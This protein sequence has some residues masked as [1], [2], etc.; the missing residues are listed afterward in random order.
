MEKLYV[1]V[2][3]KFIGLAPGEGKGR[4][5]RSSENMVYVNEGKEKS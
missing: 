2:Q 5:R 1:I 3:K 4:R